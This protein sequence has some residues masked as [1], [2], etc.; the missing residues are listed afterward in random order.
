MLYNVMGMRELNSATNFPQFL[1]A[2]GQQG[3]DNVLFARNRW[4]I[5]LC[6]KKVFFVLGML[7]NNRHLQVI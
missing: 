5:I 3:T 4:V 2:I 6:K 7:I 1:G